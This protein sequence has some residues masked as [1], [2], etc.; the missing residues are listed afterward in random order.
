MTTA[1]AKM[2]GAAICAACDVAWRAPRPNRHIRCQSR[3]EKHRRR[4][5]CRR[6]RNAMGYRRLQ[7]SL[8]NP[9][10]HRRNT[11]RYLRPPPH[12]RYGRC[13]VHS[14]YHCMRACAQCRR[15]DRRSRRQRTGRGLCAANVT[16]PI[17]ARLSTPRR[18]PTRWASGPVAMGL[19]L[20][21]ARRSAAGSS[22]AWVGAAFST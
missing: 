2:N 15:F 7:P 10:A 18:A 14:G 22:T 11:R 4:S 16:G 17:G 13:V 9:A 3:A 5:A 8:C 1:S 6:E 20:L 21:S 12:F 19:P